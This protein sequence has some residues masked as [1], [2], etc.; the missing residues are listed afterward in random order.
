MARNFV[1]YNTNLQRT[2]DSLNEGLP[3]KN[4]QRQVAK[5]MIVFP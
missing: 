1:S 5:K 3:I 4:G 2:S